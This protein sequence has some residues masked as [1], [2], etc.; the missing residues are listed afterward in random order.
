MPH[1]VRL[2]GLT[3]AA[4]SD[5]PMGGAA[6]TTGVHGDGAMRWRDIVRKENG[7]EPVEAVKPLTP[8]ASPKRTRRQD[9]INQQI[10]TAQGRNA[11]ISRRTKLDAA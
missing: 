10:Q 7:N 5:A 8:A 11:L 1:V 3:R 9:T 2:A 6:I 4:L